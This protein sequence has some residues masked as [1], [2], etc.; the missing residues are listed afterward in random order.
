MGEAIY[1]AEFR[2]ISRGIGALDAMCK[3]TR[4]TLLHA[5]PVCIGKYLICAGGDVA[6]VAEAKTAVEIGGGEP[7][8]AACLLTGTHPAIL[9]YFK[10]ESS[11][12]ENIPATVGVFETRS[13]AAGFESLDA[14]LKSAQTEL[15]RVWIGNRLG[16]KLCWVLGGGTSDIQSAVQAAGKAIPE[17]ERAGSQIISAPDSLITKMFIKNLL[18]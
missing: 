7:P 6:D 9:G 8:F 17:S 3:R 2:S 13:A 14:A 11:A 12:A 4:F 10:K 1:V 16:G 15:L 18:T 5:N